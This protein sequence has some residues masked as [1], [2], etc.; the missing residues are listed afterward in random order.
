MLA[1]NSCSST[2]IPIN[3]ILVYDV[4]EQ[5]SYCSLTT[6]GRSLVVNK[7]QVLCIIRGWGYIAIMSV[8]L[9]L[10]FL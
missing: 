7:T 2:I 1:N 6:S 3:V 8:V 5:L 4:R 10:I 9:R